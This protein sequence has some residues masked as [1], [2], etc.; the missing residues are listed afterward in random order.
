[1]K[2]AEKIFALNQVDAGLPAHRR[3]NLREQRGRNLDHRNTAHEDRRKESGNVCENAAA[4]RHYDAAAVAAS[5][6]HLPGELFH[7]SQALARL[8]AGEQEQLIWTT[9]Q[10]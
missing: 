7:F 2:T 1:M 8:A 9:V 5:G 3:I 4:E 6:H 10:T